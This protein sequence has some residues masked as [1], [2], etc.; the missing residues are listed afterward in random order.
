M[1]PIETRDQSLNQMSEL[2][3]LR[4]E[5]MTIDHDSQGVHFDRARHRIICSTARKYFTSRVINC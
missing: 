3:R 5:A 4:P 1:L 2:D